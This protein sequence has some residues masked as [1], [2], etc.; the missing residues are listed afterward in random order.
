[1]ANKKTIL[2]LSIDIS[3]K[4]R[5]L[6]LSKKSDKKMAELIKEVLEENLPRVEAKYG[7]QQ[8]LKL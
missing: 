5:L 7:I 2:S 8:K 6:E 4:D 1:M 3:L